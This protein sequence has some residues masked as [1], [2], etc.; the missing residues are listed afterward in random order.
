MDPRRVLIVSADMGEGHNATGRAL[1]HAVRA[2][3]PGVDVRW[4]DTLD[5]MGRGVGP[6]FRE[7]YVTNVRRTPW[8]Y[9]FFYGAVQ[10]HRH[11]ADAAKWFVGAWC[12]RR[13]A[14]HIGEYRPDVI[15]ST[16]PLG[17]SGLAWLRTH[18]GLAVPMGAWVSDFSPHPFWVHS[19]LDL[20]LVMHQVAV[21]PATRW[22]RGA[23]VAVSA[24]PVVPRFAPGDRAAA[25]A[26]HDLPGD[27][28]VALVSCGA[29]GFGSVESGTDVLLAAGAVVVVACGRNDALRQRLATAHQDAVATGRLRTLGWTDKMAELTVASDVVVTNAGGATSLEALACGRAVLMY[30]PIAAHGRANAEL[31]AAAGLAE[32]C[33]DETELADAIHRLRGE[34]A[35]LAAIEARSLAHARSGTIADG[36]TALMAGPPAAPAARRL[37]AEDAMFVHVQTPRVPQ[38]VG[39]VLMLDAK[40]DGTSATLADAAYLFDASPG[41]YGR[42]DRGSAWRHPRW[43]AQPGRAVDLVEPVD[44]GCHGDAGGPSDLDGAMDAFFSIPLDGSA[45]AGLAQLVRGLDGGRCALLIKLHHAAADGIAVIGALVGRTRG[46]EFIAEPAPTTADEGRTVRQRLAAAR[47]LAVGVWALARA[48]RAAPSELNGPLRSADRHHARVDLQASEV[49]QVARALG[50]RTTDL[51]T[52]LLG[53]AL[54]RVLHTEENGPDS[55]RVMMPRSTR[56]TRT[57]RTAGNR[58]GAASVDLPIGPMSLAD[59]VARTRAVTDRQVGSSAPHAA[60]A[61]VWTLGQLPPWLHAIAAR[62]VYRSTWF[63]AIAS[64]LPGAR[65]PVFLNGS[66]I[67]AVYPVLAL[68]PGVKLSVGIMTWADLVTVCFA[69]DTDLAGRVDALAEAV[70]AAFKEARALVG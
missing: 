55:L 44:L 43:V 42:I 54:H 15:L 8:L 61:V 4:V 31:M 68:A 65:S 23:R 2:L 9:E 3:W 14:R 39:A 60:H 20:N 52:A 35:Q 24:P 29:F 67:S 16:Y 22:V 53:E 19:E 17:S 36:L 34:P 47:E 69:G 70:Y 66:R 41:L 57:F 49:R 45:G 58:T 46:Q 25:R 37:R 28:F 50:A 62:L 21:E 12:G 18:R 6:A 56:T 11:F 48:G 38:Q 7:I 63:N 13:L 30:R 27:A 32:V 59:R 5:V 51:A 10:R 40:P 1:D 64:V 33:A 26:R